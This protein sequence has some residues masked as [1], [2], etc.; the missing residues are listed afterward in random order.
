MS[1]YSDFNRLR[2][3]AKKQV[4][5]TS[6]KVPLDVFNDYEIY[7]K[8]TD[9]NV[10]FHLNAYIKSVVRDNKVGIEKMKATIASS[11]LRDKRSPSDN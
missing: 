2:D 9:T 3:L 8:F 6:I 1:N 11:Q 4:K 10:N 5:Q 7:L